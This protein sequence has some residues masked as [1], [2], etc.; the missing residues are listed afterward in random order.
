[1]IC[2]VDVD[3]GADLRAD[4]MDRKKEKGVSHANRRMHRGKTLHEE[5]T[6]IKHED[7][8][9]ILKTQHLRRPAAWVSR[10]A[11]LSPLAAFLGQKSRGVTLE[12]YQS[13]VLKFGWDVLYANLM[14]LDF[15]QTEMADIHIWNNRN[16]NYA[17]HNNNE[18]TN[19]PP[20][21]SHIREDLMVIATII[22]T[23]LQGLATPSA[24]HQPATRSSTA[25]VR[26]EYTSKFNSLGT[27]APTIMVDDTLKLHH[28]KKGLSSQ[29][30]S[31]LEVYKLT[32]FADLMGASIRVERSIKQRE[33]E[34]KNKRPLTKCRRI[35]GAC[36]NYGKMGHRITDYP[37]PKKQGTG[38]D[39][40][41]VQNKPKE[42]KPNAR[43]FA[44]TQEEAEDSR[45]V[46]AGV[47]PCYNLELIALRGLKTL[48]NHYDDLVRTK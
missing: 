13:P 48:R 45:N 35:S 4:T 34:G 26:M 17:N 6:G 27:Y 23:T 42:N 40:I 39:S 37:E 11:R 38:S 47:K 41:L 21:V 9:C 43:V 36:F 32:N 7:A 18:D 8:S 44:M 16:P 30:Q 31:A 33:D 15:R 20:R 29:I 3:P 1:M 14:K 19:P 25:Y 22:A 10:E 2:E 28:F 24:N 46:V 5:A 12:W